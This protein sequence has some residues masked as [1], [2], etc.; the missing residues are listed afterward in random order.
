ML[1]SIKRIGTICLTI[2]SIIFFAPTFATSDIPSGT[3]TAD[4]KNVPLETYSG[5]SNLTADWQANTIALHWYNGNT[6]IENI[7]NAS[8][9][10][11]YDGTLTPPETIPQR[12]GYIFKGWRVRPQINFETISIDTFISGYG[13]G[14]TSWCGYWYGNVKQ[15]EGRDICSEVSGFNDLQPSEWK[16]ELSD[17][18]LYGMAKCSAKAGDDHNHT[19]NINYKS[20]WTATTNELDSATGDATY[21]WCKSTGFRANNSDTKYASSKNLLWVYTTTASTCRASCA[22]FCAASWSYKYAA[23]RSALVSQ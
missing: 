4:C 10:C 3:S 11:E 6:L 16:T 23:F 5:T 20:D 22:L 15:A 12:E 2:F 14:A 18:W 19:W 7:P 8:S 21:C 17:G 1:L 13:K 9:S